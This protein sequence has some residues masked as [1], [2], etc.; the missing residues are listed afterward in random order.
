MN[1]FILDAASTRVRVHC[2]SSV[3]FYLGVITTGWYDA[4]IVV[5]S[6]IIFSCLGCRS[7]SLSLSKCKRHLSDIN[8]IILILIF[9]YLGIF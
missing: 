7:L 8:V 9:K 1:R 4:F 3:A 2:V 6:F 5:F